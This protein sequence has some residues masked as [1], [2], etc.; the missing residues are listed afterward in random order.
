[1]KKLGLK[2]SGGSNSHLKKLCVKFN[3]DTSHFLGQ[4][5]NRGGNHLGGPEKLAA[6]TILVYNRNN[7]RRE[8]VDRLRRALIESGVP[9]Q[10]AVCGLGT[11]W[12]SKPITLHIDHIDGNF[13]NNYKNNLRFICP[14]CHTQTENYGAK[15][16]C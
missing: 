1:M 10:C 8:R 5:S 3:I 11:E 13:L 7:D 14:N 15:N 6:E 12:N 4:A 2:L 16:K 9:E